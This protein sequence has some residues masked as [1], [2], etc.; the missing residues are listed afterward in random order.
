MFDECNRPVFGVLLD[1]IT[2]GGVGD[3]V[4]VSGH[5]PRTSHSPEWCVSGIAVA[6][7]NDEQCIFRHS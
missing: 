1:E 2:E 5:E 3:G 4:N 6:L 7:A